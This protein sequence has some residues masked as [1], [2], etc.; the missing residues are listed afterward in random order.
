MLRNLE[1]A[2][3]VAPTVVQRC[4]IPYFLQTDCDVVARADTGSGKTAAY[5]IPLIQLVLQFKYEGADFMRSLQ[6]KKAPFALLLAPSRELADQIHRDALRYAKG[7]DSLAP[8]GTVSLGLGLRICLA[9]GEL[10]MK[11]SLAMLSNGCDILI[12]TQGRVSHYLFGV[13]SAG[14]FVQLS[15]RR[16]RL[17]VV[18]EADRSL[19]DAHFCSLFRR[20]NNCF[21][22]SADP[23]N[24]CSGRNGGQA[25]DLQVLGHSALRRSLLE[26]RRHQG[27]P[28]RA[29]QAQRDD[30]AACCHC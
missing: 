19:G 29:R 5:L 12:G 7:E 27:Q 1:L 10:N 20:L 8:L 4:V 21:V 3:F 14:T 11:D 13:D 26:P 15:W 24:C 16:L 17:V 30:R 28:G 2:Q 9:V 25:E 23:S 18:D 6:N 22:S